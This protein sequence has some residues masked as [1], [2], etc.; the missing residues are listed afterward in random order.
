MDNWEN[1]Y[2]KNISRDNVVE[3]DSEGEFTVRGFEA[4]INPDSTV[5]FWAANPPTYNGSFSGSGLPFPNPEIAYQNSIN[6]GTVQTIGGYY[7]FKIK[8]PNAY[9]VGLGS[10]YVE[11]CVHIKIIQE[12]GEDKLKT[13]KLGN[14]IPFR[15]LRHSNGQ[16]NIPPRNNSS[17]YKL[18]EK[19]PIRTQEQ[20]LRDSQYPEN[21]AMPSN[22]W[23]G[24]IPHP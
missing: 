1:S 2:L 11:P 17:F 15:S 3:K 4:N 18:T 8:F 10:K 13:I 20:I 19:L 9:Y 6:K 12:H 14:S 7:E 22:F 16:R 23:G 5:I 21:N 24:A